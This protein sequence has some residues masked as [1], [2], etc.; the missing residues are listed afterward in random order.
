MIF[1]FE[2]FAFFV[3]L[4]SK[5]GNSLLIL[6]SYLTRYLFFIFYK[7]ELLDI[8]FR[9]N[10]ALKRLGLKLANNEITPS[11]LLS[12]LDYCMIYRYCKEKL[13]VH[14]FCDDGK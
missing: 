2:L 10:N 6:V 4:Q 13:H 7:G 3:A 1:T 12:P 8:Y 9:R 5:F 14:H 11:E